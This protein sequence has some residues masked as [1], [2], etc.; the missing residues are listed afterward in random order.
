[1]KNLTL[2]EILIEAGQMTPHA[3]DMSPYNG[4]LFQCACG[5]N[6]QFSASMDHRNFATNGA[7]AKMLVTCPN[8]S[9]ITTLIK[10]KYKFIFMFDRFLSIAGHKA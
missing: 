9:T 3:R 6:H 5:N 8:D 2:E 7:N 1:M 10:T 4:K